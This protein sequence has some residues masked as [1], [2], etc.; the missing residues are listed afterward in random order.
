MLAERGGRA[1][2]RDGKGKVAS[3]ETF[4]EASIWPNLMG[5]IAVSF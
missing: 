3:Q 1:K 4:A 2:P 5:G